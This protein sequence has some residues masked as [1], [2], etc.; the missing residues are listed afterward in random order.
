MRDA[1]FR[2][3]LGRRTSRG[4]R[5]TDKGIRNR[6]SKGHRIE[7]ALAEM[8]FE[9]RDLDAVHRNARWPQ[10]LDALRAVWADWRSNEAAAR[11]MAPQA[12]DPTR[13][14]GNLQNVARQ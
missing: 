7:R 13:Q 1:E 10:L 14:L 4:R 5:L 9:E 3:W 11:R 2:E 12:P 6:V 8:G